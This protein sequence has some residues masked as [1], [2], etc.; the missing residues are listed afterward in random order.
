MRLKTAKKQAAM[1]NFPLKVKEASNSIE[2]YSVASTKYEDKRKDAQQR[3]EAISKELSKVDERISKLKPS[4]KL[5]KL[6][7]RCK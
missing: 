2:S 7:D 6:A 1:A 4:V 3:L 5:D